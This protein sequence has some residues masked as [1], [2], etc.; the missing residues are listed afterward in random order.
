M[1]KDYAF[2]WSQGIGETFTILVP[3]LYGGGGSVDAGTGSKSYE[4]IVDMGAGED[5]AKNYSEHLSTY[6]GAQ[7]FV[8]GPI[9]F[10]ALVILLMVLGLFLIRSHL[11]WVTLALSGL[12]IVKSWRKHFGAFNYFLF[13]PI[14]FFNNFLIPIMFIV[15]T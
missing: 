4:A 10:G 15:I 8:A 5:N 13:S 3:N 1:D 2:Q 9:Y 11:K 6:W 12:A 14:P 7:P